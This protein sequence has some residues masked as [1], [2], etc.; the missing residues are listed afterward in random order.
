MPERNNISGK[1]ADNIYYVLQYRPEKDLY[2]MEVHDCAGKYLTDPAMASGKMGYAS[3]A[4]TEEEYNLKAVQ[5]DDEKMNALIGALLTQLPKDR[6]LENGCIDLARFEH[7]E[8]LKLVLK[9]ETMDDH[10]YQKYKNE[11]AFSYLASLDKVYVMVMPEKRRTDSVYQQQR[12]L[13]LVRIHQF[14]VTSC[15]VRGE[16]QSGADDL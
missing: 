15:R 13:F 5:N 8:E 11:R 3:F 12:N 7:Q 2:V 10:A 14:H 9:N 6:I 16:G 4:L 1:Y